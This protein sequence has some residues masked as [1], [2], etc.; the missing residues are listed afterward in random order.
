H[1]ARTSA[2]LYRRQIDRDTSARN[3]T[4][5]RALWNGHHVRRRWHGSRWHF[6][7][8]ELTEERHNMATTRAPARAKAAKGGSF[9][10]E[11]LQAED[12]FTPEDFSEEHLQIAKTAANFSNQEIL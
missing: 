9:L 4:S 7:E 5:R 8:S 1:R 3:A 6:R 12:V 2:W 10:I 11:D